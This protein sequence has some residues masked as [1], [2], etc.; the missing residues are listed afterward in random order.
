MKKYFY[1]SIAV[2]CL[3]ICIVLSPAITRATS[4]PWT[5]TDWAGGSGQSSWSD[6]TK[7][8]TSSGVDATTGNR[9]QLLNQEKFS[10]TGF[11]ANLDSWNAGINPEGIT[12]MKLWLKAD[13]ITGL[14]DGGSV[15]S[16]PDSSGLGHNAIQADSGRYP[17]YET[18]ELNGKP[19]IRFNGTSQG[20][21]VPDTTDLDATAGFSVFVVTTA[22]RSGANQVIVYKGDHDSGNNYNYRIIHWGDGSKYGGLGSVRQVRSFMHLVQQSW[23]RHKY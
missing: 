16:W 18:N 9:L 6:A 17:T 14:A 13:A 1:I 10:N 7:Y 20:M 3:V 2:I 11:E 21:Y 19:V 12:G 4:A 23:V 8:S 15:S 22:Q 5:Q